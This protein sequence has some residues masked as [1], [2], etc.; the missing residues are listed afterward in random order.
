MNHTRKQCFA[1]V[2]S[3]SD[4]GILSTHTVTDFRIG[5]LA[6]PRQSG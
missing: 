3:D 4:V 6:D 2:L 1:S 5:T